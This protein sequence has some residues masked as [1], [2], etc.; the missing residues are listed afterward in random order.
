MTNFSNPYAPIPGD[1]MMEQKTSVL[2]IIALV[3]SLICL[4]P[5][6]PA[7]GVILA[8]IALVMIAGSGG[9]LGGRGLA[10]AALILGLIFTALQIGIV[11]ALTKG[12]GAFSGYITK[13]TGELVQTIEQR[14]FAK[15]R[16][17]MAPGSGDRVTDADFEAFRSGYQGDLG[18]F[19]GVATSL[20]QIWTGYQKVGHLMQA[21][22]GQNNQAE[23]IIPIPAEFEKGWA[24][25]II[26]MDAKNQAQNS[27]ISPANIIIHSQSG[28]K[29]MLYTG[30]ATGATTVPGGSSDNSVT[31]PSPP[32]TTIKIE[33]GKQTGVNV[34]V[35]TDKPAEQPAP[36]K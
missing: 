10:L 1:M 23:P 16:T 30:G 18:A 7:L 14:D 22:Q 17:L 3:C 25:V 33:P 34:D 31:L 26:Q 9:R 29:W 8:V 2:A 20:G 32:G 6:I 24:L 28:G 13:P 36:P 27:P 35:K 21:Y 19:K 11:V 12:L 5:V 15:A 4:L